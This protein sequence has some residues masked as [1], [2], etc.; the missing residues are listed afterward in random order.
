[1]KAKAVSTPKKKPISPSGKKT[2]SPPKKK[3]NPS[4]K[5]IPPAPSKGKSDSM[6]KEKLELSNQ[7]ND[8][9]RA[10]FRGRR[11]AYFVLNTEKTPDGSFIVCV[12]IENEA[13]YYKLD[14]GW[15]CSLAK[16]KAETE[17]MN[18]KL[19]LAQREVEEIILSTMLKPTCQ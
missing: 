16:A 7:V 11:I 8:F 9:A 13:G 6:A 18:K 2:A 1:M 17:L 15:H 19:G 4:A 10:A 5:K 12:A 3:P 14:W